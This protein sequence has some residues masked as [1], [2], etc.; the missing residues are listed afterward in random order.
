MTKILITGGS[1]FLGTHVVNAVK[2]YDIFVPR[3][4]E[5]DLRRNYDTQQ[6][7]MTEKPNIVIHLAATC[8]GIGANMN[9][10]GQYFY[11]NI[12]M[13]VNVIDCCKNSGVSKIIMVG[14]V[15]SYPKHCA[16]PFSEDDL[17]YG[18]PEE[19]NA[20]YGIAKKALY[21]MLE[22]YHKQYGLNSTVFIPSNLYCTFVMF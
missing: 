6:L 22:A 20:P 3:S 19:T 2:G 11:D 7:F 12:T 17:W 14:T 21:V 16:V 18:F 9:N 5:Y 8:G 1:G 13:G 15:C 10:P 4:N